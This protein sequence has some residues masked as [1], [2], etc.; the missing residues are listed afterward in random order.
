MRDIKRIK[1]ILKL[2]AR[3]WLRYPE[4][5]LGQ[6]LGN[7]INIYDDLYYIEDAILEQKIKDNIKKYL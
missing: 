2:I 6:L 7:N 4:L 3:I 5:R 1:R